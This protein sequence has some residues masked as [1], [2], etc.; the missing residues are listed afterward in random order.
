MSNISSRMRRLLDEKGLTPY[1]FSKK[2]GIS[3]ATI[4][5]ILNKSSKPNENTLKVILDYFKVDE[6]WFLIG[7]VLNDPYKQPEELVA[8]RNEIIE[9]YNLLITKLNN[10]IKELQGEPE[11]LDVIEKLQRALKLK[12]EAHALFKREMTNL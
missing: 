1:Q 5:R 7:D 2:T 8:L 12:S 3:N 6:K 9:D 10:V 4:S 11:T